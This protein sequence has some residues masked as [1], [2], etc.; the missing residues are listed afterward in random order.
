MSVCGSGSAISSQD[1]QLVDVPEIECRQV[2]GG[3]PAAKPLG[4]GSD[5]LQGS[6]AVLMREAATVEVA[7]VGKEAKGQASQSVASAMR[8]NT[9]IS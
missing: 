8:L 6:S 9:A 5:Q 7:V 4:A 1:L 3:V 2:A